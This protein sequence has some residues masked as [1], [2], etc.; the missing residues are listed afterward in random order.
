MR[1]E[2]FLQ[3]WADTFRPKSFFLRLSACCK[4][5]GITRLN[6]APHQIRYRLRESEAEPLSLLIVTLILLPRTVTWILP[7]T[8]YWLLWKLPA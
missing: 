4:A 7:E 1:R 8:L 3:R 2:G 5:I 6:G